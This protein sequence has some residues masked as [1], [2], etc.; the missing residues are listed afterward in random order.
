MGKED[1]LERR[2]EKNLIS[3]VKEKISDLRTGFITIIVLIGLAIIGSLF[4]K[5]MMKKIMAV[6]VVVI[7]S[8]IVLGIAGIIIVCV[9]YVVIRWIGAAVNKWCKEKG[10]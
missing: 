4:A 7:V 8:S 5:Y 2:K 3:M 6:D 1:V 9:L 10:F